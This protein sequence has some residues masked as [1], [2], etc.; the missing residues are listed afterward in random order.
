M[1]RRPLGNA[2]GF[3]LAELIIAMGVVAVLS[4]LGG[5]LFL[6][7]LDTSS[8]RAAADELASVLARGRQ[9]AIVRNTRVC[10]EQTGLVVRYHVGP[11]GCAE[12]VWT[13]DGT[14]ADGSIALTNGLQITAATANVVF[15]RLGAADTA[16]TYTVRY[17][18]TGTTASVVVAA[19]GR[20]SITVP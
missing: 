11:N 12:A 6:S 2:G 1:T 20:V 18:T 10:V 9:L 7:Y 16:G 8:L 4:T 17:P 19:T 13:G 14:T 5:F 3:T 15:N